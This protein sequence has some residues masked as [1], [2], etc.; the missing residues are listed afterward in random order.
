MITSLLEFYFTKHYFY[1]NDNRFKLRVKDVKILNTLTNTDQAL[2]RF[3]QALSY[4]AL[5]KLDVLS[6]EPGGFIVMIGAI[7]FRDGGRLQPAQLEADKSD[8][9]VYIAVVNDNQVITTFL[10]QSFMTNRDIIEKCNK[11]S[12]NVKVEKMI[13][14]EGKELPLDSKQRP[15]VTIDLDSDFAEFSKEFPVAR[16]KN[17]VWSDTAFTKIELDNIERL[18]KERIKKDAE[19]GSMSPMAIPA[20]LKPFIPDKEFVISEGS[21]I[22]VKYPDGIKSK[23]I[24]KLIV[25]A[26]GDKKKFT[27]EFKNTAKP[28]ELVDGM[29]F[30]ISP[31]MENDVYDK[32][33]AGFGL[34][35]GTGLSFLGPIVKFNFYKKGKGGS[36]R[37]KVGVIIS[38][39]LWLSS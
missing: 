34:E 17:N 8:G 12:K 19:S 15:I 29:P 9:N 33:I 26:T 27:L 24:S 36:D 16:L 35:S 11:D 30:I 2:P 32:L 25:N 37:D 6:T 31:K 28:M 7:Y 38:P 13:N 22:L 39:R 5:E 21:Q 4:L 3:R 1:D 20:N 10:V 14:L 23:T 18:N